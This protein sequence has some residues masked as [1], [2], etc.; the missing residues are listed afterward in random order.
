MSSAA[1]PQYV[2]LTVACSHFPVAKDST[3][4]KWFMKEP[5]GPVVNHS[6]LNGIR[7]S[8]QFE[9]LSLKRWLMGKQD[10]FHVIK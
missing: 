9:L 7:C 3:K 5:R 1:M 2:P 10:Y 8:M 4:V 6:I